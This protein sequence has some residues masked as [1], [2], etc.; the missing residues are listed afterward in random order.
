MLLLRSVVGDLMR[1][2]RAVVC[3]A[4]HHSGLLPRRGQGKEPCL[5]RSGH[6]DCFLILCRS[7]SPGQ[8]QEPPKGLTQFR[9]VKPGWKHLHR[10]T[11]QASSFPVLGP[12]SSPP[13]PGPHRV[14]HQNPA[15]LAIPTAPCRD[16]GSPQVPS[17]A[18]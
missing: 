5:P 15:P 12:P 10:R 6:S 8:A 16:W 7:L 4:A 18:A 9:R 17:S 11:A 3:D 13:I 2:G 1:M 14:V